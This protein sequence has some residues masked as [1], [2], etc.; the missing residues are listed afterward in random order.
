MAAWII[1]NVCLFNI[2][3]SNIAS[4]LINMSAF[5]IKSPVLYETLLL[6]NEV[7]M[8]RSRDRL[9][10]FS[11]LLLTTTVKSQGSVLISIQDVDRSVLNFQCW[12]LKF[13][14]GTLFCSSVNNLFRW[15]TV[16][17]PLYYQTN[18]PVDE[19]TLAR[20]SVFPYALYYWP[21]SFFNRKYNC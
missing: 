18:W 21:M 2:A 16:L 12:L 6:I 10:Q 20:S 1:H 8:V 4:L 5:L 13:S 14:P 9:L 19:E 11:L 17:K 7:N 15:Q 3:V